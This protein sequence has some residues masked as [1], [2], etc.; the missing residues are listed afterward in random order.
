MNSISA[1]IACVAVKQINGVYKLQ[2]TNGTQGNLEV[3]LAVLSFFPF[4]C[5]FNCAF[6]M[7]FYLLN[8]KQRF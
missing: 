2:Y 5:Y 4:K 1:K 8:E 7:P 3:H 6:D